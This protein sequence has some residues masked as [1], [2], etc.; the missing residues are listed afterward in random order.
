M[1]GDFLSFLLV[2]LLLQIFIAKCWEMTSV[3]IEI[4]NSDSWYYCPWWP[5]SSTH[6][7][8]CTHACI[9]THTHAHTHAHTHVCM[10]AH[11]HAHT[12]THT[13]TC[14]HT[15]VHTHTH[16]YV[17]THTHTYIHAP[18]PPPLPT[19]T[20]ITASVALNQGKSPLFFPF[21]CTALIGFILKR[22]NK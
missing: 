17:H 3:M 1:V 2:S 19:H 11:T 12:H 21:F 10:H 16:I 5:P 9:C 4:Q 6:A 13:H 15:N 7:H 20:H 8:G 18:F 14:T 22:L